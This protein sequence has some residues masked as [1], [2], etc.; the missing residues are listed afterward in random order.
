MEQVVK[1]KK[2][3]KEAE[4]VSLMLERVQPF[5][6]EQQALGVLTHMCASAHSLFLLAQTAPT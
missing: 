4:S 5:S 6:L 3:E 2:K 1:Q